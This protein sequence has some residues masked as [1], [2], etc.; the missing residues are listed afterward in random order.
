MNE[1]NYLKE[2]FIDE[3]KHALDYWN[4]VGGNSGGADEWFNDGNTHIWIT[5]AEGRTS[6]MLGVCPNGTV[7]VDWGDGTT[8]DV[9]TGTSEGTV[10]LTPT[11]NYESAGEYI[12]TLKVDGVFG[13]NGA[14]EASYLLRH[15]YAEHTLNKSY[16]AAIQKV[17]VG[18][19]AL[20]GSCAFYSCYN[21]SAVK[22]PDGVQKIDA[23][24]FNSCYSLRNIDLPTGL[25]FIGPSAFTNCLSLGS[26]YIPDG[27]TTLN[28]SVFQN[29]TG[30]ANVRIPKSVDTIDTN[31]F[32]SCR[33][34]AFCD[35]TEHTGVPTLVNS[36]AF[37]YVANDFKIYVSESIADAWRKATNWSRNSGWIVGV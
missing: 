22:I 12:I 34:L 19:G 24:A 29:C 3:A 6:P 30:L 36:N 7:T 18:D 4:G 28:S 11:H 25:T 27:V 21:L 2:M 9:L 10:V 16:T 33:G 26:V 20:I 13:I 23:S 5:L 14:N 17:E 37:T 1:S 15:Y 35:C 32:Y 31:A 8:P